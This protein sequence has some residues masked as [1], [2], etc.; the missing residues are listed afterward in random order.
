MRF[1]SDKMTTDKPTSS[2]YDRLH[3]QVRAGS[4]ISQISRCAMIIDL[5]VSVQKNSQGEG[6]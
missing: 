1:L 6:M 5:F 4:H 2:S 3:V